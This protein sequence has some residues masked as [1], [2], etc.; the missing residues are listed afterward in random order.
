MQRMRRR[1]REREGRK[2]EGGGRER[3]QLHIN[4]SSPRRKWEEQAKKGAKGMQQQ[5]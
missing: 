4:S 5:I 1:E 3:E 2:V